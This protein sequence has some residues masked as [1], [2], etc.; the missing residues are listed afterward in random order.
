MYNNN[1]YLYVVSGPSSPYS[2]ETFFVYAK[3]RSEADLMAYTVYGE[4]TEFMG[5]YS[6]NQAEMMGYDT[7]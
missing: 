6:D 1:N 5:K 3:N 4:K 7:Y 2:G